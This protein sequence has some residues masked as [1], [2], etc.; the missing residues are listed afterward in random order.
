VTEKSEGECAS[1]AD[2]Q[3][4]SLGFF[5]Y[6]E[7]AVFFFIGESNKRFSAFWSNLAEESGTRST[8]GQSDRLQYSHTWLR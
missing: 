2:C 8:H 1:Q 3:H 6:S 7:K 4:I 5:G